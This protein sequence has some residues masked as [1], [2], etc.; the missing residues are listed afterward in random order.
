MPKLIHSNP[1]QDLRSRPI[2][3]EMARALEW[4]AGRRMEAFRRGFAHDY[5]GP[6]V[7]RG[8][9]ESLARRGLVYFWQGQKQAHITQEGLQALAAW[10]SDNTEA[11]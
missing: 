10:R 5:R 8:T 4:L 9:M 1:R 11:A 2:S 7:L 3:P 6:F